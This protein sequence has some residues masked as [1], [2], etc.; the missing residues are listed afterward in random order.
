MVPVKAMGDLTWRL[1]RILN[2]G[3]LFV[4]PFVILLLSNIVFIIELRKRA[5]I[6]SSSKSTDQG[7]IGSQTT[8]VDKV[9]KA[10]QK[11]EADKER[12]RHDYT[13]MLVSI[14]CSYLVIASAINGVIFLAFNARE[15][16]EVER[17][18][19]LLNVKDLLQIINSSTNFL[20]FCVSGKEYRKAFKRA[21]HSMSKGTG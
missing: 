18:H 14:T 21:I 13:K 3:I 2:T 20:F 12:N 7:K 1:F 8:V 10:K 5:Q 17:S 6:K 19:F 11:R 9:W 16:N 15:G 4:L